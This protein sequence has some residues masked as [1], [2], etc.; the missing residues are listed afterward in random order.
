[1]PK[2]PPVTSNPTTTPAAASQATT[3]KVVE[4][5]PASVADSEDFIAAHFAALRGD[6]G[7]SWDLQARDPISMALDPNLCP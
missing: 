4:G 2:V 1:M 3:T 6:E 7:I 5:M